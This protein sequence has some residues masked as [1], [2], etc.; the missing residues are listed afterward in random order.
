[1]SDKWYR[2]NSQR[3]GKEEEGEGKDR[4]RERE[5]RVWGTVSIDHRDRH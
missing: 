4:E 2:C 5:T 1:M 3:K